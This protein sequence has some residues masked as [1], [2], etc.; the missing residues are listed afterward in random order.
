MW[1][2]QFVF[3]GPSC[4]EMDTV[5]NPRNTLA[6]CFSCARNL[7]TIDLLMLLGYDFVS[8]VGV[9]EGLLERHCSRRPK[10]DATPE[11]R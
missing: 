8:A 7:N 1:E 5:V 9:L 4:G 6:H 2:G 10:G 3:L 11:A